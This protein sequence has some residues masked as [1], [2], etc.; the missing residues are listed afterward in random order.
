M[1]TFLGACTEFSPEDIDEK[2]IA[3]SSIIY[4]EGYL[5]DQP[6]AIEAIRKAIKA[7]KAAGR[8]VAFT[9]SDQFC[10]DRHREEFLSLLENKEIDILFSNEKEAF[11]L[12]AATTVSECEA[13]LKDKTDIAVITRSEKGAVILRGKNRTEVAGEHVS[14]VVDVTGAGD[15]FAAG[16]LFGLTRGWNLEACARLGNRCAS[17]IIQQIGARAQNPLARLVA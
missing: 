6:A 12:C 3:E 15:L 11:A 17:E 2:K 7:A 13:F 16:F 14:R 4:V 1:N 8:T 10:V 5:W 9:L